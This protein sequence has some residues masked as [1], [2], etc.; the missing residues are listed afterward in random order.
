MYFA[1]IY[2]D[3]YTGR[4]VDTQWTLSG[5]TVDT[6]WTLVNTVVLRIKKIINI[7]LIFLN[8]Q[9]Y[10]IYQCPLCV[11]CVSTE[12]PVSVH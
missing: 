12:C 5:H 3:I 7:S 1:V 11:H 6:Q 9:N 10:N 2:S 8:A 4:S